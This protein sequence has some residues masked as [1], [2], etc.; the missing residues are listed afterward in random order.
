MDSSTEGK[1][2]GH[3]LTTIIRKRHSVFLGVVIFSGCLTVHL[4][5]HVKKLLI[6]PCDRDIQSLMTK[7]G[8]KSK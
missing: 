7:G 5:L 6:I 1:L 4:T 3:K 8:C 2:K